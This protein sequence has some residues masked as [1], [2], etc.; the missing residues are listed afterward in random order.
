[1]QRGPKSLAREEMSLHPEMVQ[2]APKSEK[3]SRRLVA[4]CELGHARLREHSCLILRS[5]SCLLR[6]ALSFSRRACRTRALLFS[7][8]TRCCSLSLAKRSSRSGSQ[9][10]SQ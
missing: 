10:E 5:R 2:G 4:T 7:L 3:G 1:M 8:S 6:N 9:I